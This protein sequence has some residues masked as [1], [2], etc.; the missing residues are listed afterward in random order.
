MSS[1]NRAGPADRI[2]FPVA[3]RGA[4]LGFSVLLIGILLS[5]V[6]GVLEPTVHMVA[7]YAVYA[8]AF[9]L[10]ARKTGTATAP[11][12]HGATAAAAAYLLVLPLILRDPAGRNI[13]Q[14]ALTLALAVC[15]G[16]LTGWIRSAR[17]G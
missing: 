10:A 15:V 16:A 12:L 13:S 5:A 1:A 3:V 6:L 14:V 4:S 2:D 8:L 11:A 7:T 17:R 9:H